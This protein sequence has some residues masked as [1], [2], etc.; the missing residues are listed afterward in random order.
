M[1]S[2][3]QLQLAIL[4]QYDPAYEWRGGNAALI[5]SQDREVIVEGGSE[6]GKTMAACYKSHMACR[7]YPKVQGALVRKV[8]SSISGTVLLTLKRIIGNFP[9]TY[10]GG[11]HNP[12]RI[13][14]PNGSQIWIGGMDNPAKVLSG[15]RDFIQVC[16][17]EEMSVDDWE[18][19]TTRTTGRGA[20]M[21]YTQVFGDC[22]PSGQKHFLL[23]RKRA[24]YLRMLPTF[25]Q[26]NPALWDGHDWTE[27]G[28]RTIETLDKLTGT[29]KTRLRSGLW[30]VSEGAV[31]DNVTERKITDEEIEQFDNI[32]HGIDWGF[33]PDPFSYGKMHF[34]AGQ[35]KL[36]IFDEYRVWRK[37]NRETYDYLMEHKKIKLNDL[38]IADSNRPESVAD[39]RA[40]GAYC[41][42]AQKGDQSR[43]YSYEW[44]Q[45][46]AEIIIDPERAPYHAEEFVGAEYPKMR[47]GE[48]ISVY[49]TIDDHAIDDVR[50]ATNMIWRRRGE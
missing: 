1:L 34:D 23:Q 8:A 6:T 44:L 9:V 24:G 3:T 49:P 11:D 26:D 12:E 30:G 21:P 14:Y 42:A 36:Y 41:R 47:D 17:A 38:I 27:Q 10:Y 7:E 45:G 48:I 2:D 37:N 50:Y 19:M 32:L 33:F 31:F 29:R 4:L 15:E 5:D 20:V 35:R 13:I 46:L 25:H 43:R 18:I 16:Q 39:Y 40:Y 22:N 28:R